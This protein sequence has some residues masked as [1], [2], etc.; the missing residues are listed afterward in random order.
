MINNKLFY[1]HTS[2]LLHILNESNI[3][4]EEK[5]YRKNEL[6]NACKTMIKTHYPTIRYYNLSHEIRS[7]EFLRQYPNMKVAQDSKHKS[8]C[9]F[10]V[11]NT[12]NI[13]CICSSSG[14]EEKNGLCNFH[15]SGIFDYKKKSEILWIIW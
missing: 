14:D 5:N 12:Y 15:G 2:M 6:I 8:G 1:D 11:Y 7:M 4:Q 9:D 13:E 10:K 3:S